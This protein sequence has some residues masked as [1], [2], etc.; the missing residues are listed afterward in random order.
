MD[1]SGQNELLSLGVCVVTLPYV[2][3]FVFISFLTLNPHLAL[4]FFLFKS[5]IFSFDKNIS[6]LKQ[7]SASQKKK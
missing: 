7:G 1:L 3:E 2:E 4:F 5:S 6:T